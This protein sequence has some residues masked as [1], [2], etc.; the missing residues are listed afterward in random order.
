MPLP[1][2]ETTTGSFKVVKHNSTLW[3]VYFKNY[4]SGTM[5]QIAYRLEREVAQKYCDALNETLLGPRPIPPK[6][7]PG[8]QPGDVD[9][10]PVTTSS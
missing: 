6:E 7:E 9:T 8:E 5:I 1:K 3:D 4:S 10:S 2:I